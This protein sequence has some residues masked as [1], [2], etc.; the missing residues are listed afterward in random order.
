M[1]DLSLSLLLYLSNKE[2]EINKNSIERIKLT[3]NKNKKGEGMKRWYREEKEKGEYL[4]VR[5]KRSSAQNP[6]LSLSEP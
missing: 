6:V 2:K 5:K 3:E 1:L 4:H